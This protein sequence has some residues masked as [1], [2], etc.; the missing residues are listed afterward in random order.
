MSDPRRVDLHLHTCRSDG[1]FTPEQL[2]ERARAC[3]LSAISI[4]DHDDVGSAND[5]EQWRARAGTALELIP[6]IELTV[7]FRDRELHLLGYDFSVDNAPLRAFLE[8]ARARRLE[9]LRAMLDRLREKKIILAWE[10]LMEIAALSR[11]PG[12]PH[13]AELLVRR[14]AVGSLKEAY[15]RYLGDSASCFVRMV[16]T[17]VEEACRLV[18]QAGGVIVLAHPCHLVRDEWCP[19]LA[20]RGVQ[21]VEV[22]HSEHSASDTLFYQK[23]AK[24]LNWIE[25]G[26]SDCH[27]F[28]KTKGPLIGTVSVPYACLE[29]IR[30]VR[31]AA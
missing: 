16:D 26:G 2:I 17:T 15:D 14:R 12:R 8:L 31:H 1:T 19:E 3:G 29:S 11:S 6:G 4:T 30:Q 27:G 28:Q 25:T 20:A 18:R 7:A 5:M 10:E 22:Y 23:V 21:G 24:E 13:L 9:R